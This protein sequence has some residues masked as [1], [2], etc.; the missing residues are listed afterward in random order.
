[1]EERLTLTKN[2]NFSVDGNDVWWLQVPS[3][4]LTVMFV[5][6]IN[7]RGILFDENDNG[8][9]LSGTSTFA[10]FVKGN[11]SKA[12]KLQQLTKSELEIFPK[13]L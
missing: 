5:V 10:I 9:L 13:V 2:I 4:D 1:M 12:R 8:I 11:V 7:N 3:Q 6:D